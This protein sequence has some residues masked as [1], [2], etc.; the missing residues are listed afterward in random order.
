MEGNVWDPRNCT[1][2][3]DCQHRCPRFVDETGQPLIIRRLKDRNTDALRSMYSTI[4]PDESTM[5]IPPRQQEQR[6][7]WLRKLTTDGWNLVALTDAEAV[8]GHVGVAPSNSETPSFVIFV[9]ESHQN[10][11]IGSEL[12]KQ[13]IAYAAAYDHDALHLSVDTRNEH[14]ISVYRNVDFEVMDTN[15]MEMVMRLTLESQI[16]QDVQRPP[17]ER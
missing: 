5:G 17:A 7:Q 1:G 8:I 2:F 11:G 10:Q 12:L 9:A 15:P 14:A 16:A 13:T 6:R 4:T 3:A